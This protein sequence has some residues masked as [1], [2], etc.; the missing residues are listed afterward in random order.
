MFRVFSAILKSVFMVFIADYGAGNLRSVL[1][2][3]DYLGVKAIVSNDP[4]KLEGYKKVIL[5]GVGAFG[6]AI[7]SLNASGFTEA[8]SEHVDKGGQLLGICLGMQLLLTDSEEMGSHKG[9]DLIPGRVLQFKSE[10]DKI[11]QIGWN[12]VDQQKESVLFR[13]IPDHSFFYFVHSYYCEPVEP[14]TVAATTW[15]AGKN[16]CSAI[17]KNGI[18]AVQ[19]HPEKSSEAG[20]QVLKNFAEC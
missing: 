4:R 9:M 12:S 15:F 13:G 17:E 16:F 19:F 14:D 10:T 1:K 20:L 3:F 18:F 8:I 11:P 6:Q 7:E 2:A 5:P